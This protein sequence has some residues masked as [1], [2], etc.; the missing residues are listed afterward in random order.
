MYG[1][2]MLAWVD[3]PCCERIILDD[4]RH[5]SPCSQNLMPNKLRNVPVLN[6]TSVQSDDGSSVSLALHHML[7]G[8]QRNFVLEGEFHAAAGIEG[9][10][11][12]NLASLLQDRSSAAPILLALPG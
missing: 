8:G 12:G 7:T 11:P 1:R 10:I 9:N 3:Q 2:D 4:I 6:E 5:P